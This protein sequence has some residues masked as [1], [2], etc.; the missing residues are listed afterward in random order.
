MMY[1]PSTFD[2]FGRIDPL[3]IWMVKA[4]VIVIVCVYIGDST[5]PDF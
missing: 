4:Y 1:I 3:F 2:T 5:V